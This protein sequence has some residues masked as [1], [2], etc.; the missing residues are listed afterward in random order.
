MYAVHVLVGHHGVFSLTPIW[1]LA[2]A[3]MARLRV[4]AGAKPQA[5]ALPWF[6]RPLALALSIVVIAFYLYSS[7]NYGGWTQGLRWLMWL[8]PIWLTCLLPAADWLATSRWGR[9]VGYALLAVSVFSASYEPW[10][11]WRHPWLYDLM[12]AFGWEGY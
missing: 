11:P 8:T 10:N 12:Q 7:D 3:G 5:L 4:S 2:L 1:V 6:V 9:G